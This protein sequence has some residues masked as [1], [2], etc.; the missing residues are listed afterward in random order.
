M[1][2]SK[3]DAAEQ[4]S[5]RFQQLDDDEEEAAV[6]EAEAEAAARR[7]VLIPPYR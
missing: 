1:Q 4:L 3:V 7:A 5:I 2:P 6:K